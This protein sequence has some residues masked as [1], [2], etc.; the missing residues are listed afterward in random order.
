MDTYTDKLKAYLAQHKQDE[1]AA[2]LECSQSTISRYREGKRFPDAGM[3]R[4]I[5]AASNGAVPFSLWQEE[6]LRRLTGEAA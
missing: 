2:T 1:V 3:A 6:I 4:S 5:D